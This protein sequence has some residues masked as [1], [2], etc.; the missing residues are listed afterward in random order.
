MTA[1][2]VG[3]EVGVPLAAI[4]NL[5]SAGGSTL[6]IILNL[7]EGN[8]SDATQTAGFMILGEVA[9]AIVNKFLPGSDLGSKIIKQNVQLKVMGTQR[10]TE[11]IQEDKINNDKYS[12]WS[13]MYCIWTFLSNKFNMEK[14][15]E[16]Y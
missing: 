6:E 7:S 16:K 13:N 14:K 15:K 10:V 9:N 5:V 8:K 1:T 2:V 11:Y 4:R 12:F 3:A